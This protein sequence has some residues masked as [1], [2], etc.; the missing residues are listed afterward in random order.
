MRAVDAR[1]FVRAFKKECDDQIEGARKV[2]TEGDALDMAFVNNTQVFLYA[3]L[4]AE[5]VDSV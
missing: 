4:A 2:K 1:R 3:H 5:A